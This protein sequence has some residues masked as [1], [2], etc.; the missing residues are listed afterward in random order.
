MPGATDCWLDDNLAQRIINAAPLCGRKVLDLTCRRLCQMVGAAAGATCSLQCIHIAH[1]C[2]PQVRD[3]GTFNL[4]F[5]LCLEECEAEP[6]DLLD[7]PAA[8]TYQRVHQF[9]FDGACP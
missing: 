2:Y 1:G 7:L 6:Q 4:R 8:R 9:D 3:T 5:N